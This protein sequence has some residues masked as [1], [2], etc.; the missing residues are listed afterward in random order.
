MF[1]VLSWICPELGYDWS[2]VIKSTLPK[3]FRCC[4]Q[5]SELDSSWYDDGKFDNYGWWLFNE[6]L[7][8]VFLLTEVSFGWYSSHSPNTREEWLLM[9]PSV[10][11]GGGGRG[12][13]MSKVWISNKVVLHFKEEAMSLSIF[14]P[15]LCHL[16]P[17]LSGHCFKAMLLVG[18]LP[19]QSFASRELV[20]GKL[21]KNWLKQ[22]WVPFFVCF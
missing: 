13:G 10:G 2:V 17:F 20:V 8:L 12:V 16:S 11:G 5:L 4:S 18:N 19:Y 14:N 22:C 15:S 1:K 7:F 6:M 3:Y 21:V 9:R